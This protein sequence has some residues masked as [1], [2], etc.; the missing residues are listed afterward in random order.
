M[1]IDTPR[2]EIIT[3]RD[4]RRRYIAEQKLRLVERTMRPGMTVSAIARKHS[5]TPSLLFTWFWCNL[6]GF[7]SSRLSGGF[8]G[9]GQVPGRGEAVRGAAL[10]P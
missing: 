2:V 6:R 4:R 5:I 9:D 7:V 8:E 1:P 10:R 3:G